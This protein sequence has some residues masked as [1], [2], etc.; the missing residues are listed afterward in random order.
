[1]FAIFTCGRSCGTAESTIRGIL[2]KKG[3]RLNAAFKVEMPDNFIPMFPLM[4]EEEQKQMLQNADVTLETVMES[5]QSRK[6]ATITTQ[7]MPAPMKFLV[8]KV[9]VPNQRKATK[10]F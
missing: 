4:P 8:K 6:P 2:E 9:A 1:M 7:Q 5:I 3:I 10:N